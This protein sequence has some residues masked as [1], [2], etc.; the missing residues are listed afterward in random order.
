MFSTCNVFV[1]VWFITTAE[2]NFY[3]CFW[4]TSVVQAIVSHCSFICSYIILYIVFVL[5]YVSDTNLNELLWM[6]CSLY[7]TRIS[8]LGFSSPKSQWQIRV[9]AIGFHLVLSLALGAT[10]RAQVSGSR[11]WLYSVIPVYLPAIGLLRGR[12]SVFGSRGLLLCCMALLAS[13][14]TILPLMI[15]VK[16]APWGN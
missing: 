1:N 5:I 14:C 11:A 4:S 13:G 16:C 9:R 8:G 12:I 3:L 7:S 10:P 15:C 2:C 6:V